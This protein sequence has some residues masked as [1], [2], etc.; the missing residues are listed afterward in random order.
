MEFCWIKLK[1]IG[2]GGKVAKWIFSFLHDRKQV[3]IVNGKK[4]KCVPVLSGVPQGSVLGPLLFL[5][6]MMDIDTDQKYSFLSS[7]A[8]DTRVSKGI[9]DIMDTFKLQRDLNAIYYWAAENNMEFNDCK[10]QHIKYGKDEEVSKLSKYLSSEGKLIENK[11]YV[12]DL[13]VLMSSDCT[14]K[15]HIQKVVNTVGDMSSWILRTFSSRT[16]EVMITLWKSLITPHLDYCSQLWAPYRKNK[17]QELE[18]TQRS[19]VRKI[20]G[21]SQHSYWDQLKLLNLYSIQRRRE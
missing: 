16:P 18:M 5:I 1:S 17:I 13:G 9:T 7:F 14:F 15:Q 10:F 21:M 19:Y 8:D 12:K 20:I 2:I 3:V 4:S 6:M 11:P